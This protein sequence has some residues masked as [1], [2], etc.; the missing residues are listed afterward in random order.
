MNFLILGHAYL[1]AALRALGHNVVTASPNAGVDIKISHP[2]YW[3]RLKRALAGF[4]PDVLLYL[5]DGNLPV[6]IDPQDVPCASIF[7]SIDTYCNPWHVCYGH[8]FD[9]VLVAQKDFVPLF[10]DDGQQA[11]WFP[12]FNIAPQAEGEKIRTI[13]VAFVGTLGHK[14]NQDREPFLHAFAK[15]APL[16]IKSGDY[17]PIFA[18]SLIAL[19]QTAF[20]EVNFRCFEAMACGCALLTEQCGNG[21]AE[22]FLEGETILPPYPR[23]NA[24]LAAM[25]ACK[26]LAEPEL[27][28]R[29][30][31]AGRQH[32]EK[33]HSAGARAATLCELCPPLL[34][35][36][37]GRLALAPQ[38]Q[39][40][41][42][43]AFGMIGAELTA[44]E[45]AAH[46]DFYISLG[47]ES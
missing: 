10:T 40:Y 46:R 16:T 36:A 39:A 7:Y 47:R 17:R 20:S 26:Y 30:A 23:G 6:L 1:A 33:C 13:P 11:A 2:L 42:R 12:L 43:A 29:I 44:P 22:L 21:L 28:A 41:V 25:I 14:N 18:K 5:D 9:L 19:N 8:G 34:E 38:R 31:N 35:Q 37:Q 4:N 3:G 27:L 32:V 45:M 15:L 24:R